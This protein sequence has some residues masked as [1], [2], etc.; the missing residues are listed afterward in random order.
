MRSSGIKWTLLLLSLDV[1]V[2]QMAKSIAR[3]RIQD[4]ERLGNFYETEPPRVFPIACRSYAFQTAT[5]MPWSKWIR[6][7]HSPEWM[8]AVVTW[9]FV[10]NRVGPCPALEY[11]ISGSN[12]NCI[13]L[14]DGLTPLNYLWWRLDRYF[15][16]NRQNPCL[17][18]DEV[19]NFAIE[20]AEPVMA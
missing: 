5:G 11:S 6:K 9:S 7:L 3:K 8:L 4:A 13:D 19:L 17:F 12:R 10:K 2:H 14:P 18:S 1:R 16:I 20:M 15:G